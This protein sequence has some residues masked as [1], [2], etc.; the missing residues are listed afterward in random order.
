M[1]SPQLNPRRTA[2][3]SSGGVKLGI[4]SLE[5]SHDVAIVADPGGPLASAFSHYVARLA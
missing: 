3:L 4:S 5:V 1:G 2:A